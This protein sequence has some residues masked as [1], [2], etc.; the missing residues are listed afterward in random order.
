MSIC[1][2]EDFS[3]ST[4]LPL[5]HVNPDFDLRSGI[6][7]LRERIERIFVNE[8]IQLYTRLGLVEVM[9]ERSGLPVN[10]DISANLFV[11]GSAVL[12]PATV[13]QFREHREDDALFVHDGVLIGATVAGEAL[14]EKLLNWLK[15]GLIR[16]ELV[17]RANWSIDLQAFDAPVIEVEAGAFRYPWDL[18]S[19]NTQLLNNDADFFALGTVAPTA[20]LASSA[21]LVAEHRIYVGPDARVGAGAIIDASDGPVVI[22]AGA[23]IMPQALVMGPAYIGRDSRI[24]AGAKIYEGTTVGPSCKVGGEVEESIFHS[25]ANKQHDGFVGHSYLA[26]WTNLGADTN[27]SDLKNNYSNIRVHLEGREYQT[28]QMFIGT[29]LADH[30]KCGINTMFN[31]GTVVSV[32]CNVYGGDFPPKFF[33]SFSWGGA[34]G[35]SEYEFDRFASTAEVVMQRRGKTL[36]EHEV[37]IL[38]NVFVQTSGQRSFTR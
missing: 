3:I 23:V 37:Q 14:R 29:I 13:E 12:L 8:P 6:F 28:G 17:R 2:F 1:L 20:V 10:D 31:T 16:E 24:K 35:L 4:L 9:K 27:T 7:T 22:D 15:S 33:P 38:R 5:T 34:S 26:P 19:W 30:S 36:T 25:F 11:N 32:G 21:E 18:L